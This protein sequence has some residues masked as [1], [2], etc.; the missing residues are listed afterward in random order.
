MVLKLVP[1]DEPRVPIDDEAAYE[2]ILRAAFSSRRKM[3]GNS[4]GSVLKKGEADK[5]LAT[6]GIDRTRRAETLSVEEFGALYR[7]AVKS[8]E[9][10]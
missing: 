8:G 2:K 3:L 6:A 1:L 10:A 9:I 5:I 7:E 4:L